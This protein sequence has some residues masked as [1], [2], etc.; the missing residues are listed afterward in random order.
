[1]YDPLNGNFSRKEDGLW[2]TGAAKSG[3]DNAR[4]REE[5]FG[6]VMYFKS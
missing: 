5:S 4:K 6:S 1:M 2:E 3:E